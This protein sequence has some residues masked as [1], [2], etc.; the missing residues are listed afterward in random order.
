MYDT[1]I[2][3][4]DAASFCAKSALELAEQR[5]ANA[6]SP[7]LSRKYAQ[8]IQTLDAFTLARLLRV[9]RPPYT[10]PDESLHDLLTQHH[11]TFASLQQP[12]HAG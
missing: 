10:L 12:E 9:D 11:A 2:E 8:D 4:L 1:T 6:D 5:Q 3:S 7:D